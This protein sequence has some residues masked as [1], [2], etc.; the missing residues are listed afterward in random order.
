MSLDIL[1]VEDDRDA[2]ANLRDIQFDYDA[3]LTG[4]GR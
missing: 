2:L 3:G 4:T 1:A